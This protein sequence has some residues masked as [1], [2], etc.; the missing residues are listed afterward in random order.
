M[1]ILV[2]NPCM[3]LWE[4]AQAIGNLADKLFRH[5]AASVPKL[6]IAESAKRG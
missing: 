2:T 5:F 4:W 3:V 1:E 6:A